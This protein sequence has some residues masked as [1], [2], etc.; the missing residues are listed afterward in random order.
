VRAVIVTLGDWHHLDGSV[1]TGV[2]LSP[3]ELVGD[4]TLVFYMVAGGSSCQSDGEPSHGEHLVLMWSKGSYT[5]PRV[6]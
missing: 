3:G 2:W 6:L 4:S 1:V 5:L